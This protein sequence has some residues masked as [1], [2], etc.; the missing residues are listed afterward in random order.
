MNYQP[1]QFGSNA[2][3]YGQPTYN[4]PPQFGQPAYNQPAYNQPGYN[5]PFNYQNSNQLNPILSNPVL[6]LSFDGNNNNNGTLIDD[7]FP[8]K[9]IPDYIQF[10][11][12]VTCMNCSLVSFGTDI[13]TGRE[14]V[15]GSHCRQTVSSS[16][17]GRSDNLGSQSMDT[18]LLLHANLIST[19]HSL[20]TRQV[21]QK[22]PETLAQATRHINVSV[23]VRDK[24]WAYN[25][26]ENFGPKLP[27]KGV[28]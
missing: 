18:F 8:R 22:R 2:P 26:R 5:Q 27:G 13:S 23:L 20:Q 28:H 25:L 17:L 21:L 24:V 6:P 4:L 14:E 11:Q 7:R 10:N 19:D 16:K 9:K 15:R 1:Q 3:V 12:N